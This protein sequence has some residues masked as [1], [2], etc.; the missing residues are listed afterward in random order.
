MFA[1]ERRL[2][3]PAAERRL[4]LVRRHHAG[5]RQRQR[6]VEEERIG[7]IGVDE[8]H[9]F[10]AEHRVGIVPA[11]H[12]LVVGK[13]HRHAVARHLRRVVVE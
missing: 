4:D 6:Q 1:V 13:Q 8:A 2:L 3:E 9:R 7:R 12:P 11:P 5:M 10:V